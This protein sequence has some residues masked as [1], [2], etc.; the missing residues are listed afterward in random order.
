MAVTLFHTDIPQTFVAGKPVQP[1]FGRVFGKLGDERPPLAKFISER[2]WLFVSL[3]E[4]YAAWLQM[5]PAVW[6]DNEDFLRCK[7]F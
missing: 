6:P 4:S 7:L 3:L 2:S 1:N 5:Y